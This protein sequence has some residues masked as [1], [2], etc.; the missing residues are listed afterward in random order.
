M[1][2]DPALA[3]RQFIAAL[4]RHYEAL[5]SRH[6]QDDPAVEKAYWTLDE[7]FSNYEEAVF[8]KFDDELPFGIKDEDSND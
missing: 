2:Q 4:E 3:L 1:A 5:S 8:E 6:S 7:A